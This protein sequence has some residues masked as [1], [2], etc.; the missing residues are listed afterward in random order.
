MTTNSAPKFICHEKDCT[1]SVIAYVFWFQL[2]DH[3]QR[4]ILTAT[5]VAKPA[6]TV[7]KVIDI[8]QEH[9]DL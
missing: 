5:G 6:Q 9:M 2:S 3:P 4:P 7:L 8:Q 1:L